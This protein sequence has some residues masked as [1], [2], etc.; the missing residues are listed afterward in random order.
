MN[1]NA[2]AKANEQRPVGTEGV[3]KKELCPVV[4]LTKLDGQRTAVKNTG[5]NQP[6]VAGTNIAGKS[7]DT[8]ERRTIGTT[9]ASQN[10]IEM[11]RRVVSKYVIDKR[12]H[13]VKDVKA[14]E[15]RTCGASANSKVDERRS[16]SINAVNRLAE[17]ND[18]RPVSTNADIGEQRTTS[19]N[20]EASQWHATSSNVAGKSAGANVSHKNANAAERRVAHK[21]GASN[22]RYAADAVKSTVLYER[23]ATVAKTELDEQIEEDK[24]IQELIEINP[25]LASKEISCTKCGA[26]GHVVGDCKRKDN[27]R[28]CYSCLK[29]VDHVASTCPE[30]GDYSVL[31]KILQDRMN[32]KFVQESRDSK[33][34]LPMKPPPSPPP[35][36][37]SRL[38]EDKPSFSVPPEIPKDVDERMEEVEEE[39]DLPLVDGLRQVYH[40]RRRITTKKLKTGRVARKD[41]IF[42]D[43]DFYTD[44]EYREMFIEEDEEEPGDIIL[45][46][47][48]VMTTNQN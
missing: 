29:F 26:Y 23:R 34:L 41:L 36:M 31:T 32:V 3:S 10:P 6:S 28:K 5:A 47:I 11:E 27:R 9:V 2:N 44:V 21:T 17:V 7:V 1:A 14:N 43:S 33:S 4:L 24:R 13:A 48:K 20:I 42:T 22:E 38:F 35:F 15:Q 40:I 37:H 25:R 8:N 12:P 45:E 46:T 39:D 16:V 19:Q 18:P 30:R